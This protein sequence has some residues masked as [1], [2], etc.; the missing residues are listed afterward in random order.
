MTNEGQPDFFSENPVMTEFEE[1]IV[2]ICEM[3]DE[4]ERED[5]LYD[6][7]D[8]II[9]EIKADV[10]DSTESEIEDS[11]ESEIKN[12]VQPESKIPSWVHDIFVW[13]ADETI[14]ENELLTAIEYLIT[15]GAIIIN[16]N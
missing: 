3:E 2:G 5:A 6:S 11:V 1:D 8:E 16:T 14:S 4:D 9:L 7:I 12:L 15:E 13:Y 10:E